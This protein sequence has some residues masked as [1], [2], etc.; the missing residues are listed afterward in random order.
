MRIGKQPEVTPI[1][2]LQEMLRAIYPDTKLSKD[3][4][5]GKETQQEVSRFQKD[6]GLTPTGIA[7]LDT[8][9]AIV[10][11]Y[12]RAQIFNGEAEP[13]LLVLQPQQV[14]RAGSKNTHLY[15]IQ[16]VLAAL[17]RYYDQMPIVQSTGTLDAPTADAISWFQ[18]RS[19]LPITGELDKLTW[20]H[21]AKNYRSIVG[22]GSGSYP[23]RT[24]QRELTPMEQLTE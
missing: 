17:A 12:E 22:D 1:T 5:F 9:D 20:R 7:D 15:V 19:A 6:F 3:G 18:Q 16:G 8:W 10:R 23:I 13:L 2:D 11:E 24:A 14:L 4:T 21:L